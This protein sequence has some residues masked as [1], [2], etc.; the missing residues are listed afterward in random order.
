MGDIA[1]IKC[2]KKDK[3]DLTKTSELR[4]ISPDE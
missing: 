4:I 1:Y 2:A 3:Q